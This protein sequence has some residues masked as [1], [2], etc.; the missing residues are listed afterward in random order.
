M[1]LSSEERETII[2]FDDSENDASIYTCNSILKSKLDKLMSERTGISIVAE[3]EYSKT[4]ILP[5]KWVKVVAPRILSDDERLKLSN[6]MKALRS[7]MNAD[8]SD[9]IQA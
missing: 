8:T 6:R 4:Y 7:K 5:K 3:D 1:R 9:K 2:R